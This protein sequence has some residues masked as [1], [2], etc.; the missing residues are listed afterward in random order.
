MNWS[1]KYRHPVRGG[2]VWVSKPRQRLVKTRLI[3]GAPPCSLVHRRFAPSCLHC[4]LASG[5]DA[6]RRTARMQHVSD[7]RAG[8][9]TRAGMCHHHTPASRPAKGFGADTHTSPRT[10]PP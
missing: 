10:H 7:L 4:L 3:R 1:A 9:L 5:P 6:N 8:D 2:S